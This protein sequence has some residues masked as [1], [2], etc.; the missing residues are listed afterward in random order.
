MVISHSYVKIPEGIEFLPDEFWIFG[1]FFCF[2]FVEIM[3]DD[4]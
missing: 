1:G 3:P 4:P 2:S